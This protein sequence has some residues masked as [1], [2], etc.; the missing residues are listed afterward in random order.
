MIS[1]DIIHENSCWTEPTKWTGRL[2]MRWCDKI[3]DF[4]LHKIL[5]ELGFSSAKRQSYWVLRCF[6]KQINTDDRTRLDYTRRARVALGPIVSHI[7]MFWR[8]PARHRVVSADFRSNVQNGHVFER[9]PP[10]HRWFPRITCPKLSVTDDGR[11][12]NRQTNIKFR[13]AP[14]Q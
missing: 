14:T 5:Y 1:L 9:G 7:N 4:F 11:T 2:V 12:D 10:C 3:T 13:E 6:R 8:E